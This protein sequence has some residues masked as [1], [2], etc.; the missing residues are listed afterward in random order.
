MLVVY[1]GTLNPWVTLLNLGQVATVAGF[2]W[3]PQMLNPLQY[4]ALLPFHLLSAG[5]IPF[6][7]NVF[8]AICAALSLT[9]LARSI[10]ILPH[11]RTDM[12]RQRERSDFS[13]LTGWIAFFPPIFA[14]ILIG[15]QLGFW[16]N[17]TSYTGE[18]FELLLFAVILWQLL[19]YRL[20]EA[21][22]RLFA[23][24]FI[25][26]VG[27]VE[28]WA[29]VGYFPLFLA[30]IIWLRK[31]EFF[32]VQFLGRMVLWGFLGLLFFLCLP[33]GIKL[34]GHYHAGLWDV[35]KPGLTP[36][37]MVI[38][39]AVNGNASGVWHGLALISLATLLPALV[40]SIRWSSRFG[41]T[42]SVST[43]L[44]NYLFYFVHGAF[45]T[46]CVWV[47]FDPPFSPKQLVPFPFTG[48]PA[49]TFYY[50]AALCL[51]YYCGFFLL[52][53][54]REPIRSRR[55]NSRTTP[56]L[57]P[58]L[59]W[60]CPV[61]AGGTLAVAALFVG[62]LIYK[63]A[64]IIHAVND[65]TLQ[66]Y[67][68]FTTQNLPSNGAILLCDADG[69]GANQLGQPIRALLIQA[70][71]AREGRAKNY[72]V[73]DTQSLNWPLY[74]H[75]LHE[76]FPNYWPEIYKGNETNGVNPLVIFS[77]L[78]LLA[79]S[80]NICYLNPSFG[81]YFEAF[82]QEPH[83]LSYAMDLLSTNT[84]LPPPL[85]KKLIAENEKFWTEVTESVSP[86]IEKALMPP[87]PTARANFANW[88][89]MHLHVTPE[90]NLNA[91]YVGTWY[92]RN[93]NAWGVELQRAGE[94]AAA[95]A[96]FTTAQ[97]LN[98]DN[99]VAGINLDFN[100]KLRSGAALAI[101]PGR[102]NPDQFG[103]AR[104][105]SG[106]IAANG[107]FDEVSFTYEDGLILATQNQ[108]FR[109]AAAPFTRVRELVPN[110][111][112]VRLQLAQL[113]VFNRLPDRA[114][115]ALHDPMT[116]PDRFG[117]DADNSTGLSVLAATAYFQK[118]EN[119]RAVTLLKHE[120]SRHPDDDN[121]LV[122]SVQ[123]C[124]IHNLYADAL[125]II[126]HKLKRTPDDPKW[127]FAK[128]FA[129]LQ[130][131]NYTPAIAALTRVL[132]IQTNDPTAR[133]NRALAY[134]AV[135]KFDAAKADYLVLQ[136]A[137]TNSFQVAFGL[138]EV[139]WQQHATNDAISSYE[140]YLANAPTNTVEATNVIVRLRE[141]KK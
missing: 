121:L 136:T 41:D 104:S 50:L 125:P 135:K 108:F 39:N 25:Y 112:D 1:L 91:I 20:D 86:G 110:F 85:D 102:V 9:M 106:V 123:A 134:L 71:L 53:F 62:L 54:G 36:S 100:H 33:L 12:E 15:L 82:Y 137:Y 45:F 30:A 78:N 47:M 103:K 11:D 66:K 19:E 114:L 43:T 119:A 93:L 139:A 21:P 13:F 111:L 27:I 26:G 94:L 122:A 120:I 37:W 4:L 79:K 89:L 23:L 88:F 55:N 80:N 52:I 75:F 10:A 49:L 131:T 87:E 129:E 97:D 132:E 81:Y 69:T 6:A 76:R 140:R 72:P 77:V 17:A 73:L 117:L 61:I 115:E 105:W 5:K 74:Q 65:N 58:F 64:P 16:E 92:S 67:A 63:N 57:P 138:G 84:L 46:L 99:V 141:L 130:L 70:E 118:N 28:N 18:S 40:M 127:L 34:F 101:E 107:P 29:F 96:R 116:Q 42:S 8:S 90:P 48:T 59:M 128:G 38:S 133:F 83:G 68:Q 95:A 113:Y 51:G 14:V 44:I 32:N 3:Q 56:A 109:Q 7:L 35:L 126:D 2:V 124:I 60:L 98:P 22:A 31:M 24:A